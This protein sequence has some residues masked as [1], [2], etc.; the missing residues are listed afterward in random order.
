[1][2]F[3]SDFFPPPISY[4]VIR[5][6]AA[7]FDRWALQYQQVIAAATR[8]VA[9]AEMLGIPGDQIN[10]RQAIGDASVMGLDKLIGIDPP[11]AVRAWPQHA[12]YL[13]QARVD[14]VGGHRRQRSATLLAGALISVGELVEDF[15]GLRLEER[16]RR[17]GVRQRC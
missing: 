14:I 3:A 5:P 15:A 11:H 17:A 12:P 4:P 1:M 9:H 8:A 10:G 6:G 2:D 13:A 7:G 16:Q